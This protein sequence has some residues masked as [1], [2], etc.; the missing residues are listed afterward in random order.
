VRILAPH[1]DSFSGYGGIAAAS[2]HFLRAVCALE[3]TEEVVALPRNQ[4]DSIDTTLPERLTW[5]ANS[6]GGMTA[7]VR[8]LLQLLAVDRDFD[9]IWCGHLHLV[10]FALLARSLTGAPVAVQVHGIEAWGPTKKWLANRLVNRVDAFISVSDTTKERLTRWSGLA[11]GQGVVVPNTVDFD[12]LTPG[13][14]SEA[15]LDR[16]GLYDCYVLMTMGRLVGRKR[17][18]G[19]DRVL[20]ALPKIADERPNVAYLIVG[21]GDDRPRLERKAERLGVRELVTFAGYVPEA[22][23][24]D[25]FRLADLF[26]MPSEGEGFGLVLLE[27]LACGTPVVASKLDGGREAVANGDF[28][29]LVDPTDLNAVADAL[30]DPPD[31]PPRSAVV[32]RFGPRA[33]RKRVEQVI[34]SMTADG[35]GPTV[36]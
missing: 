14:K 15:L 10:P 31:V 26:A 34:R 36:L 6:V 12:D 29:R 27:A 5:R 28:G 20:E 9:L 22:E 1:P 21:K 11:P 7:L 32:D 35:G 23:K 4:P 33:Y 13:P 30:T 17:R 16:Y 3:E 19:F 25:H 24:A 18:K 8:V 2:R